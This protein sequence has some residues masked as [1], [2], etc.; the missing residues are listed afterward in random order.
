[1]PY[2]LEFHIVDVEEICSKGRSL[3]EGESQIHFHS[4]LA[5]LQGH[6]FDIVHIGSSLQYIEHWQ[7]QLAELCRFKPEYFLMANIPAGDIQTYATAQYYYG[8]KVACWFFSVAD[9]RSAMSN[10][11][12]SAI[13]K[14]L[15]LLKIFGVEQPY[16]QDNFDEEYR[17]KHPCMLIFRRD[18]Q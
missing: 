1:M 11:G 5:D 16:P 3:F 7:D 2:N 9:L 18:S 6:S 15:Y 17:V 13:F 12:Y 8:S 4:S 10:N 14:S